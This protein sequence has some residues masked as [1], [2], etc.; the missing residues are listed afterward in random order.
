MQ[1]GENKMKVH[2]YK[3]NLDYI[4]YLYYNYDNRV[5]YNEAKETEYN[6]NRPYI[7]VVLDIKGIQY[8]APLEHP[9]PQH[10]K[11][12]NNPHVIKIKDGNYGLIGL[13]NMIPAHKAQLIDFDISKEKN[14]D[15]LLTQ[16]IFCQ[17]KYHMIIERALKIYEKRTLNPNS[18][19]EKVYCDFKKLE[20]GM[21]N[22]CKENNIKLSETIIPGKQERK[23]ETLAEQ[24]AVA[25]EEAKRQMAAT[26]DETNKNHLR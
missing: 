19:E 4:K 18:F 24:I 13:N 3:I 20:K 21:I 16:F 23:S 1:K 6:Q 5:Q 15:I 14:K 7:G 25:K 26:Y 17:R 10:R 9:R 8:F 11:L 12:K 22:Y 2:L